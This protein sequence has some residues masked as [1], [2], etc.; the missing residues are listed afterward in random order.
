MGAP[1]RGPLQPLHPAQLISSLFNLTVCSCSHAVLP[2]Q[3]PNAAACP[4]AVL[5]ADARRLT[6]ARPDP[7][8][9]AAAVPQK[10]ACCARAAG[11]GLPS[12][13]GDRQAR[14]RNCRRQRESRSHASRP[15][16]PPTLLGSY[17]LRSLRQSKMDTDAMPPRR[18]AATP[19]HRLLTRHVLR[20]SRPVAA[21]SRSRPVG[22]AITSTRVA[23]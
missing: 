1:A 3:P 5:R 7:T 13:D 15:L 19:P 8:G 6:R 21:S 17:C 11:P 9:R 4:C 2:R 12:K 14:A 10:A 18:H 16:P 20:S 23:R 22:R